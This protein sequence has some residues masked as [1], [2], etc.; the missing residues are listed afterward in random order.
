MTTSSLASG[1]GVELG[2]AAVT[3]MG[4]LTVR[5]LCAC[6]PSAGLAMQRSLRYKSFGV[7]SRWE[8]SGSCNEFGTCLLESAKACSG[9]DPTL[10]FCG[11]SSPTPAVPCG[12]NTC[13]SNCT[14]ASLLRSLARTRCYA[15]VP[16]TSASATCAMSR[17]SKRF[18][19]GPR[20][21]PTCCY[22]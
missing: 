10:S 19:Y 12:F 4:M 18:P 21:N 16:T 5:R 14:P 1:G 6:D 20:V 22:P 17:A 13:R 8:L 2:G 15:P 7:V 9:A 3:C 11:A